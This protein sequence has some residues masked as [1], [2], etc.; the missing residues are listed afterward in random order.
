MNL[1]LAFQNLPPQMRATILMIVALF[2]FTCMG[3]FIRL[4]AADLPVIEVVFFRN[5]L[6]VVL[7]VPLIMRVGWSSIRMQKPKL[8]F[9]R[10]VINF[11]GMF[12]G[13]TALTLIPLA[14]M[15]ALSF[16]GPL[17]V[18]IGAVLFLGEI[19]RARRMRRLLLG[20]WEH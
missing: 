13:F 12:C 15:T 3:I 2:M 18:T 6:A 4:S 10:A 9:L 14:Q 20:F 17:F 19:I 5:A 11:G 16:T 1:S 7:L 8:F